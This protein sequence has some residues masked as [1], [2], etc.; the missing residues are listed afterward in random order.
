MGRKANPDHRVCVCVCVLYI[1]IALLTTAGTTCLLKRSVP[2]I[3]IATTACNGWMRLWVDLH[4]LLLT[5]ARG[6]TC[7]LVVRHALYPRRHVL[8]VVHLER[9]DL[10]AAVVGLG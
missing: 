8:L 6:G 10:G 2:C 5:L 9:L 1:A 3:P 7:L 4:R